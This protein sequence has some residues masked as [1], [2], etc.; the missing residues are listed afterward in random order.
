MMATLVLSTV[1]SLFGPVGTAIGAFIGQQVDQRLFAPKG[2]QGPRLGDLAV[3]TSSYGSQIPHVFGTMRVAGTVIWATDLRE[4]KT[5]QRAGK[6]A[7]KQTTYSYSASFAVA[8]SGRRIAD[9][10]RIWA[11]GKLLRGARGDMKTE[12]KYRLYHGGEAQTCDPLIAA[13]D[14]QA[15]AFRGIAY[16]L[17]EDFQLGEYGNRIPSLTFEVVADA[18]GTS[19]GAVVDA[20]AQ[21]AVIAAS[22]IPLTGFAA[23]GDSVRAVIATLGEAAP[24][25]LYDDGDALR[26]GGDAGAAVSL[27]EASDAGETQRTAASQ[28]PDVVSIGYYDPARDYQAGLQRASFGASGG[29]GPGRREDRVALPAAIGAD[30]A[31]ALAAAKLDHHW[32][33]RERRTLTL[34]WREMRA[35]PGSIVRLDGAERLWRVTGWTLERMAV[36]LELAAHA[37]AAGAAT[38]PAAAGRGV[39]QADRV[40]GPTVLHLFDAPNLGDAPA[41]VPRLLLAA[42]GAGG[43]RSATLEASDD[44]GSSWRTAGG[45]SPAAVMGRATGVLGTGGSTLFDARGSVEV[46]LLNEDMWL[47]SRD[48]D[49]LAAGDNLAMLGD[50]LLQFGRAQALGG[51]RF[52]L[53]R[54]LR[55][56]RGT[57]WAAD[58]HRAGEPFTLIEA[59]SLVAVTIPLARVGGTAV[60]AARGIGDGDAPVMATHVIGLEAVRPP[61]PVNGRVEGGANGALVIRWTRRSRSGWAW[62]DGVDAPLGEA[63]EA[64]RVAISSG[65]RERVIDVDAAQFIYEAAMRTED[66]ASGRFDVAVEQIGTVAASRALRFTVKE[67]GR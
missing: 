52:R 27:G 66:G 59:E 25:C 22:G 48:D 26:L 39:A 3:Q 19:T 21:G 24:A 64:Y 9:V 12:T 15:P 7:P 36:K 46:A 51:G 10:G 17:F 5:K 53:S 16:A 32:R 34:P 40:H 57:E 65:V 47:E 4:D 45:T 14:G 41:D 23:H 20:I 44:G 6:G 30:E 54:F 63:R 49:A 62:I 55:G 50:E 38:L 35:R 11:D 67:T 56:R 60:I 42:A 29:G 18:D 13:A 2:G 8:L 1:G 58:G 37:G 43:W 28:V 61:S 33:N 31:K